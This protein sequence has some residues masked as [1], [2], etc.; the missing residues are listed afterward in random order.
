MMWELIFWKIEVCTQKSLTPLGEGMWPV[1]GERE[2]RPLGPVQRKYT[3]AHRRKNTH[4][5]G[6]QRENIRYDPLLTLPNLQSTTWVLRGVEGG[7]ALNNSPSLTLIYILNLLPHFLISNQKAPLSALNSLLAKGLSFLVHSLPAS[8]SH[9]KR[10]QVGRHSGRRTLWL[11]PWLLL[12]CNLQA[13]Q[14]P[15]PTNLIH[16]CDLNLSRFKEI[17]PLEYSLQLRPTPSWIW[18]TPPRRS[19]QLRV[20][21]RQHRLLS[22]S[23]LLSQG[24]QR[25][26][27]TQSRYGIYSSS[28]RRPPW[29]KS[30]RVS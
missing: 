11:L 3:W 13:I 17:S 18:R 15:K 25:E 23:R 20:G 16:C 4:S 1:K 12:R 27:A 6:Q 22:K 29:T 24:N 14:S 28:W 30:R 10:V 19:T 8:L 26:T 21:E 2:G 7:A 9:W 5:V